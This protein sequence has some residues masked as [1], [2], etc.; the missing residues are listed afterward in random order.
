MGLKQAGFDVVGA[1]EIDEVAAR[2]YELNHPEVELWMDDIRCVHPAEMMDDLRLQEYDLDL[3]AGCPPCQGFSSITTLNGSREVED[4][5]NDL[6]LQFF[7]FVEHLLPK[8]VMLENVPGL[9]RDSRFK[10]LCDGLRRIG[11]ELNWDCL[12]AAKYG[13]PQRRRRLILL[14]SLLGPIEFAAPS[15]VQHTVRNA[16]GGLPR[17]G[18]S[19][20]QLHDFPE[21]RTDRIRQHIRRIRR[22]GGSRTELAQ[23]HQLKCHRNCNG[24][25]DIYGRMAWDEVAPTITAGC[26]NPSKGRFLHPTCDR[27]ITMREAALLQSFPRNYKFA[28]NRGKTH[29]AGM[30]GN[31]LPPAFVRAHARK[32][33]IALSLR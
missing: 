31:A 30:I 18:K 16:I 13:V 26:F 10:H 5:R 2:T 28:C 20:D 8:T 7:L 21:N 17:A 11:Y 29:V 19:G 14:G 4:D 12:D 9:A 23:C 22:D 25:K 3:L 32:L 24:F 6:V 33:S 15:R 27:A 1:I